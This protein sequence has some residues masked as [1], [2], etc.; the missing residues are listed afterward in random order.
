MTPG[1]AGFGSWL[2]QLSNRGIEPSLEGV[3]ALCRELGDPQAGFAA[4]QVTGTNGKTSTARVIHALLA[5]EGLSAGLYTSPHLETYRE[6]IVF[7]GAEIDPRA[8]ESLGERVKAAAVS[9]EARLGD[10][11]ITQFEA[12]T[13]A[14]LAGF[15]DRG[16]E[17][18]VLEVGM[19]GRW[20]ATSVVAPRVGL[21]TNV[22]RDHA[23]WLGPELTDIAGEKSYVFRDGN[24]AVIGPLEP[25]AKEV[26]RARA[27]SEGCRL[28]EHGV[29][30]SFTARDGW[31]EFRTPLGVYDRL[32]LGLRGAWQADNALLAVVGA[33]AYLRRG[34]DPETVRRTLRDVRSPGRA[35]L[36]PGEPQIVLDGA[37]NEAGLAAL[38][39]WWNQEFGDRPTVLVASILADKDVASMLRNLARVGGDIIFTTGENPRS[40]AAAEL[41]R[42]AA[43]LGISSTA[44]DRLD[45]A[46]AQAAAVAGP[47]G[48]VLVTGSLYLVGSARKLLV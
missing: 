37:H 9:A 29:D 23:E 30:F 17:V 27:S 43:G 40:L 24:T 34:F 14:A 22:T 8:F 36:L 18:A 44:V 4:I 33:E 47:Q 39:S 13:A 41:T 45:E 15:A 11:K 6:R 38:A 5:A 1:A 42:L 2:D 26:F 3:R 25:A 35:E 20:D 19:G 28:L 48:L 16:V 7:N 32:S 10:R 46:L 12:I 31:L 21:V